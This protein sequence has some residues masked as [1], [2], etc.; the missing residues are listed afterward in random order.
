MED[1][2]AGKKTGKEMY[3]RQRNDIFM[4]KESKA[5]VGNPWLLPSFA[6]MA[7]I[8]RWGVTRKPRGKQLS[9]E[10]PKSRCGVQTHPSHTVQPCSAS[11]NIHRGLVA[12]GQSPF[13]SHAISFGHAKNTPTHSDVFPVLLKGRSELALDPSPRLV[14]LRSD[15]A[16]SEVNYVLLH[17]VGG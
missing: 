5:L 17:G 16:L 15:A 8:A 10:W 13:W 3:L 2:K 1:E 4:K 11:P 9:G 6:S 7:R 14:F 12:M